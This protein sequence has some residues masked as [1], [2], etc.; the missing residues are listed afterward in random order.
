MNKTINEIPQQL[1]RKQ[2]TEQIDPN[3]NSLQG[4]PVAAFPFH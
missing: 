2:R 3:K 4:T 1:H